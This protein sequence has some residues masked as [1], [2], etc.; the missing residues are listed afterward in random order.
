MDRRHS[1]TACHDLILHFEEIGEGL[2]ETVGPEMAAALGVN[3]LS[4][5]AHLVLIALHRTLKHI[6]NAEFPADFLRVDAC[7]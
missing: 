5:D 7:P 1:S 6:A 4:I 2:V 3:Q